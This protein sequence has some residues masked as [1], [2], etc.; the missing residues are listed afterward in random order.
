MHNRCYS[1]RPNVGC[2]DAAAVAVAG[3][4]SWL[5]SEKV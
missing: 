1:S 5:F 2:V 4:E 3:G